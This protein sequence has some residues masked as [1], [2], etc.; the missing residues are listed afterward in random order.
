M[1][2][3]PIF[4]S[5]DNNYAPFISTTIA[6]ICMNTKS[7]CEFY[8]LDGGIF[9]ETKEKLKASLK[10]FKNCSLEFLS[11]DLEKIFPNFIE[12]E[13]ITK[14]MYSRFLIPDL[15]PEIK[16]ALY[17]DVDVIVLGDI[18]KMFEIDLQGAPL[19]AVCDTFA[20]KPLF[21]SYKK[22]IGLDL[23]HKYFASGNLIIDCQKWRENKFSERLLSLASNID[24]NFK[25]PDQDVMNVVFKNNYREISNKYCYCI[26]DCL[27]NPKGE[28]V[29]RHFNS[30]IKPWHLAPETKSSLMPNL[31]DFWFYAEQTEFYE[32]MLEQIKNT[33]DVLRKLR[34]INLTFRGVAN[35]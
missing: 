29:I 4:L 24:Q 8:I 10:R 27:Q 6:S 16:K 30:P 15:K 25:H 18:S 7:F 22:Q 21:N 26:A 31:S 1:Q 11:I 13:Y 28:I 34:V 5:S 14:S 32:Y 19:G 9:S 12:N 35:V 17:T 2:T 33:E 3:I 20:Q 23:N